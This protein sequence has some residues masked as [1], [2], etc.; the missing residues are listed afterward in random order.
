MGQ[1]S[2]MNQIFSVLLLIASS[3]ALPRDLFHAS[4]SVKWTLSESCEVAQEKIVNQ[5][6]L[7]DNEDC[8][9]KPGDTSPH[10]QKCLYKHTGNNGLETTGTHTTPIHRYVDDLTFNFIPRTTVVLLTPSPSLR[11]CLCWTMELTTA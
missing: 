3:Q 5:M 2:N 9:T 11:P 6:N 7:W 10:G 1:M 8:G 4:C